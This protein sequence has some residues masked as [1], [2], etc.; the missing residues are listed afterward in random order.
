MAKI[1]IEVTKD[2]GC[3]L[4]SSGEITNTLGLAVWTLLGWGENTEPQA[5]DKPA[6]REFRAAVASFMG[7]VAKYRASLTS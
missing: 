5:E 3:T 2:D 1:N 4:G 6:A 7:A